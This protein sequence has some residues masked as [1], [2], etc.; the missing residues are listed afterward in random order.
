MT[1]TKFYYLQLTH[2]HTLISKTFFIQFQYFFKLATKNPLIIV[3]LTKNSF[4]CNLNS[5]TQHWKCN[6]FAYLQLS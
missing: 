1:S 5:I 2:T 4:K 6:F 3:T